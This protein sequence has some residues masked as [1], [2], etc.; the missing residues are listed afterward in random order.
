MKYVNDDEVRIDALKSGDEAYY[1]NEW[2]A[3]PDESGNHNTE[4][5]FYDVSF[6]VEP[7]DV[8]DGVVRPQVYRRGLNT[9]YLS[10][11][12]DGAW[13]YIT[14]AGETYGHDLQTCGEAFSEVWEEV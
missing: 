2:C 7:D 13:A 14:N 11:L 8:D 5:T 12:I 6:I 3:L 1:G 10:F 4:D 9:G